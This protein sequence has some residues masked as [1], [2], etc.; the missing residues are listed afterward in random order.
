MRTSLI[1]VFPWGCLYYMRVVGQSQRCYSHLRKVDWNTIE[2]T[3]VRWKECLRHIL[4]RYK[5]RTARTDAMSVERGC[6]KILGV[7]LEAHIAG[8]PFY[9][10]VFIL[11]LLGRLFASGLAQLQGV[12]S[13]NLLRRNGD[14][15]IRGS[16]AHH[17]DNHQSE[18]VLPPSVLLNR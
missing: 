2:E 12:K 1:R 14:G 16:P 9:P 5:N 4:F 18:H 10:P 15:C 13:R 6:L 7:H 11:N 3:V 17:Y 8:F